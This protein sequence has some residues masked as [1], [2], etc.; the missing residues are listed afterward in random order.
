MKT[1]VIGVMPQDQFRA[2]AIPHRQRRVQGQAGRA[3]D[4]VHFHEVG[5]RST[6]RPEARFAEGDSGDQPRFHSGV[7]QGNGTATCHAP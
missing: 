6:E 4:L 7:G 1:I 3:Q 2:R 5:G